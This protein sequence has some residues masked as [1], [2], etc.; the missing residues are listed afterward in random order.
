MNS[1]LSKD[2][3]EWKQEYADVPSVINIGPSASS[4]F[5]GPS[6]SLTVGGHAQMPKVYGEINTTDFSGFLFNQRPTNDTISIGQY[7]SKNSPN[8]SDVVSQKNS[9][10]HVPINLIANIISESGWYIFCIFKNLWYKS[11]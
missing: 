9:P 5:V 8:L 11:W 1:Q 3:N 7:F 6:A 2:E 4:T 10:P